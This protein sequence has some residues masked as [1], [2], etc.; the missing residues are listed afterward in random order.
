MFF[1]ILPFY[2]YLLKSL[3]TGRY[4]I[5]HT[6]NLEERLNRHNQGRSVYTRGKGPWVILGYKVFETRSEAFGYERKLKRMRRE[7]V[8]RELGL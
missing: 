1:V 5:G 2:V 8:L 6:Q 3:S 7:E 4:Y